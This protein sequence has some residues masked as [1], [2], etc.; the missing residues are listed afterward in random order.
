MAKKPSFFSKLIGRDDAY[1]DYFDD[2][3]TTRAVFEGEGG[4][5]HAHISM[6]D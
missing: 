3:G 4:E 5:R 2:P 6:P 1:G